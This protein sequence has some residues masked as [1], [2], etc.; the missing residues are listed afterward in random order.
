MFVAVHVTVV[1]P[2]AKVLPEAGLQLTEGV[3]FPVAVVDQVTTAP[4]VPGPLLWV[5]F[6]GQVIVGDVPAVTVK[7]V[8]LTEVSV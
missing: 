7:V 1:V 5:M 4:H 6:P 3:G 2:T 8:V